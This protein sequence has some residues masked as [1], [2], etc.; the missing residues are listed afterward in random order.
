V[1]E[2]VPTYVSQYVPHDYL[3]H[4]REKM[5]E[6]L[7]EL[8]KA[9]P[10]ARI[11]LATGRAGSRIS[12]WADENGSDCIVIASHEPEIADYLLGSTAQHVV[13]HTKCAVHIVR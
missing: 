10:N 1:V 3:E 12:R 8:A 4:N 9:L 11:H 2:P 13:R 5:T 7:E 6:E